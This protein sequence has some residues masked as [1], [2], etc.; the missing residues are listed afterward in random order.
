[1]AAIPVV[2]PALGAAAAAA[3]VAAGMA[4]VAA[5]RSQGTQGFM[6][7]GYTGDLLGATQQLTEL[8]CYLA[9]LAALSPASA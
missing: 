8:A 9:L 1:M 2:G 3:A 5:I 7:G 6:K 4:N